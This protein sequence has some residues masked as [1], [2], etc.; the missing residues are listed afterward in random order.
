MSNLWYI[1]TDLGNGWV[2]NSQKAITRAQFTV[3]YVHSVKY[4]LSTLLGVLKRY[5][6]RI[7]TVITPSIYFYAHVSPSIMI[8]FNLELVHQPLWDVVVIIVYSVMLKLILWSR[9]CEI[10]LRWM[11]LNTFDDKSTLVQVMTWCHQASSHYL[12][13]CWPRSISPYGII[14]PQWIEIYLCGTI[15]AVTQQNFSYAHIYP[16]VIT[17]FN[18]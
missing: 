16:L 17:G 18:Q 9:S 4:E 7:I 5:S 10:A 11:P 2:L 1:C 13:Q 15:T 6:Y 8:G 3:S 14:G 12:S